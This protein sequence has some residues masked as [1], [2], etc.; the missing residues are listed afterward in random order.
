MAIIA[1]RPVTLVHFGQVVY[2]E[3][4]VCCPD[5]ILNVQSKSMSIALH[6]Q[7]VV[8]ANI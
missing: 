3:D 7:A 8:V 2:L 4:F 6:K 1:A 5:K